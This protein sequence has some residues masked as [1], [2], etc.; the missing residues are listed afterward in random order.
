MYQINGS[1]PTPST[2]SS[3]TTTAV[4]TVSTTTSTVPT[5]TGGPYTVQGLPGW[6]YYGCLTEATTGRALSAVQNPSA[7][8]PVSVESCALA[9]VGY[10]YFGVEYGQECKKQNQ[11]I[12]LRC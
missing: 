3:A 11:E 8:V 10:I 12:S 9:C 7:A 4:G 5:P 1:L 6:T 2:S